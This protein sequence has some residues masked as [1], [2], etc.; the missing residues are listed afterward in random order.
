MFYAFL[1][2]LSEHIAEVFLSVCAIAIVVIIAVVLLMGG[3]YTNAITQRCNELGGYIDRSTKTHTGFGIGQDGYPVTTTSSST[4][5]FCLS[6]DG[7]ILF[8]E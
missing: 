2:W 8:I 7:R 4:T 1:D 5:Y 3:D 6:Q